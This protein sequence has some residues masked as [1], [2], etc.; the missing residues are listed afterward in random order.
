MNIKLIFAVAFMVTALVGTTFSF[1]SCDNDEK[2]VQE[3]V[4]NINGTYH[5]D[6]NIGGGKGDQTFHVMTIK[7]QQVKIVASQNNTFTLD[8]SGYE[9]SD[10]PAKAPEQYI[11]QKPFRLTKVK[12]TK[13]GDGTVKL[14][15]E[16]TVTMVIRSVN[17]TDKM[18][19]V[20]FID[21]PCTVYT[22]GTIKN[23]KIDITTRF[24]PGRMPVDIIYT[25]VSQK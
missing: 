17:R 20:K 1:A 18:E 4:V 11:A 19:D 10:L 13:L 21:Y 25:Y 8:F 3:N 7:D 12:A 5:T 23:G 24:R 2:T 16:E 14:T 15:G 22:Q 9:T 6:L